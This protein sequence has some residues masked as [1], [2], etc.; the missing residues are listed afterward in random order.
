VSEP[1]SATRIAIAGSRYEPS[2][3]AR[4]EYSELIFQK[5]LSLYASP[6]FADSKRPK[7]EHE[8]P[9]GRKKVRGQNSSKKSPDVFRSTRNRPLDCRTRVAQ[10]M[11]AMADQD[12]EHAQKIRRFSC[13]DPAHWR[14]EIE[15][16]FERNDHSPE[17]RAW[18]DE[19]LAILKAEDDQQE[20]CPKRPW[21]LNEYYMQQWQASRPWRET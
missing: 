3:F 13:F 18:Y 1:K 16:W 11:R 6:C 10:F 2:D 19:Q 12:F 20:R 7:R 8:F 15:R 5:S 17:L 4:A 21:S 9:H 14:F